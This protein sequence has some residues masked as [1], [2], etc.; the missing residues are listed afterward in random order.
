M[1]YMPWLMSCFLRTEELPEKCCVTYYIN[2]NSAGR[3]IEH[4]F[5]YIKS[6]SLQ[7]RAERDAGT[8]VGGATSPSIP[9]WFDNLGMKRGSRFEFSL[10]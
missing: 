5:S 4:P 2:N 7:C 6:I 1:S 8:E 10:S 3:K 9:F